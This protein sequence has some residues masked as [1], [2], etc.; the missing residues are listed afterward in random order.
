MILVVNPLQD[1]LDY[2]VGQEIL[3]RCKYLR[4]WCTVFSPKDFPP[5]MYQLL[6]QSC[7]WNKRN[8]KR[9]FYILIYFG[10]INGTFFSFILFSMPRVLSGENYTRIVGKGL[11]QSSLV[12]IFDRVWNNS[13]VARCSEKRKSK[14]DKLQLLM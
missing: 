2:T 6:V 11:V 14:N 10:I 9:W 4:G 5:L 3:K 8:T 1:L 13:T 7:L 12:Y